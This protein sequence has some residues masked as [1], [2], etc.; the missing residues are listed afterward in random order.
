MAT[1]A[2][3]QEEIERIEGNI[4]FLEDVLSWEK[5]SSL[6][7]DNLKTKVEATSLAIENN[8]I[9]VK[10]WEKMLG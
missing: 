3:I 4:S 8:K 1:K 10:Y 7:F 6:S 2:E 9:W 5:N